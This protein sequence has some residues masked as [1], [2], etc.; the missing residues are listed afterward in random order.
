MAISKFS[1]SSHHLAIETGRHQ[2]P[3]VPIDN[4]ICLECRILEDELHHLIHCS[5][6]DDIRKD[7]YEIANSHLENFSN[8]NP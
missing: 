2:K 3:K 1:C 8:L 7:L 4:R 5:K 6:H